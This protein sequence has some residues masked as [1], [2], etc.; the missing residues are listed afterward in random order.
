MTHRRG[1]LPDNEHGGL[2]MNVRR[3]TTK[4]VSSPSYDDDDLLELAAANQNLL[5]VI[6]SAVGAL[7]VLRNE[8]EARAWWPQHEVRYAKDTEQ[9]EEE[10]S[11]TRVIPTLRESAEQVSAAVLRYAMA[12]ARLRDA[13]P[14]GPTLVDTLQRAAAA[15]LVASG[16]VEGAVRVSQRRNTFVKNHDIDISAVGPLREA[17]EAARQAL[18]A[19]L[20]IGRT[21]VLLK[22]AT[23]DDVGSARVLV[24]DLPPE[25]FLTTSGAEKLGLTRP[26]QLYVRFHNIQSLQNNAA[27]VAGA[28]GVAHRLSILFAQA[29]G[30]VA[31]GVAREPVADS[32]NDV[33]G[34]TSV[35]PA[36]AGLSKDIRI[37][38]VLEG[39]V[40][41]RCGES[42]LVFE[43]NDGW[44]FLGAA[45]SETLAL[46][47]LPT[48]WLKA[49]EP[50]IQRYLDRFPTAPLRR[51]H[52][53]MSALVARR[54]RLLR[55]AEEKLAG[56]GSLEVVSTLA[57]RVTP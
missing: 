24:E 1:S 39:Q 3:V 36:A 41:V 47:A 32:A 26:A 43:E 23:S 53:S 16:I 2:G 35:Q 13:L 51:L 46:D 20:E 21:A 37:D 42:V 40:W 9:A 57:S 6:V 55:E 49:A 22:N 34:F 52:A 30:D 25:V 44:R 5:D 11:K 15:A 10:F 50:A 33:L 12:R 54:E 45:E 17:L 7:D 27:A 19:E 31:R 14:G 8:H 28:N 18:P 56:R 38:G 48:S 4:P 29:L